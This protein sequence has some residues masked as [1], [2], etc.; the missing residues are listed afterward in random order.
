MDEF[1]QEIQATSRNDFVDSGVAFI[2]SFG[3]FITIFVIGTVIK[4]VGS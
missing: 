2:V 4:M 3:F 1:E